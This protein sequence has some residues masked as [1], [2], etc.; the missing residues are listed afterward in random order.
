MTSLFALIFMGAVNTAEAR[1]HHSPP[2]RQHHAAH[3]KP[4]QSKP[5][6]AHAH[7]HTYHYSGHRYYHGAVFVWQWVPGHWHRHAWVR[8]HWEISYRI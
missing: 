3:A 5:K 2:P 7:A 1:P 6:H 4:R 8:G